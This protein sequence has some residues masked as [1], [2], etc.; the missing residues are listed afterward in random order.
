MLPL[1][2]RSVHRAPGCR[3]SWIDAVDALAIIGTNWREGI[4]HVAM[5]ASAA[6]H[7]WL[8]G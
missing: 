3:R 2:V 4:D 8:A 5:R 6:D 1:L 7:V